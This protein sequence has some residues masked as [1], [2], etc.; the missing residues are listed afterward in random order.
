[1]TNIITNR[2]IECLSPYTSQH[3]RVNWRCCVCSYEW[4]TTPA[5]V[6]HRGTGCPNCKALAHAERQEHRRQQAA[7][8]FVK[9]A[10]DVHGDVY[11]YTQVCYTRA[12]LPV[13][14]GCEKHGLFNQTPNVHLRGGGC[15]ECGY[16]M[17]RE[18]NNAKSKAA[19]D[20]F[21]SRG[22]AVHNDKYDY[23]NVV[24]KT[25]QQLVTVCCPIHGDF[26]VRPA[27]H[28]TGT[29]CPT[30]A[31]ENLDGRYS[32]RYF[33]KYPHKK[34]APAWLYL[35]T[36]EDND[37]T[38]FVKVGITAGKHIHS[39]LQAYSKFLIECQL[40]VSGMTLYN[41]YNV[42]QQVLTHFATHKYVPGRQFSGKTEC[43]AHSEDFLS[44][45]ISFLEEAC[46]NIPDI[47]IQ[48]NTA[49]SSVVITNAKRC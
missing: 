40:T 37:G 28:I 12:S 6:I 17:L 11:D 13:T 14:I 1:M 21:V 9:K 24:Y 23:T 45:Y 18:Y 48:M 19:A 16:D 43:L 2:S 30:C 47:H 32:S 31:N 46:R 8:E 26:K 27:K 29:G 7:I 4:V 10:Q 44:R 38:T 3:Q 42:E 20:L 34:T 36:C 22:K 5:N 25:N 35:L 15:A 41:A 49:P 39:R 33:E